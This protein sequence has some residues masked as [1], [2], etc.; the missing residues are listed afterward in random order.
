LLLRPGSL[1]PGTPSPEV[2][3]QFCRVP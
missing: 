3:E 1:E 2:T